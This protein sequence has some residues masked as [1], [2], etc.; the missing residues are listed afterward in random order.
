MNK[1]ARDIAR[2]LGAGEFDVPVRPSLERR[3][4]RAY[5]TMM[6]GDMLL[7]HF[8]FILAGLLYEGIWM[9]WRAQMQAQLLLPIFYT[10]ALYNGTY[11][12]RVLVDRRYAIRKALVALLISATLLNFV[13]FYTK[14]NASFSRGSFTIGMVL[15][16]ALLATFR[17]AVADMVERLWGGRIRNNLVIDDGGPPFRIAKADFISASDLGIEPVNDDP[18]TLDR[19]GRLLRNQD[20]VVVSCLPGRHEQWAFLLKA[21]GVQGEVVSEPVHTLGAIG[22]VQYEDQDL[23]ALVVSMG[24]LG[25]R[26][27]AA[28]RLFDLAVAIGG[29]I[30]LSPVLIAA[31][32]LIKLEDGG[33]VFFVQRRMGRGNRLFDMFKLR[34][35]RAE[36]H[37]SD[38]TLS[39]S[40]EDDRV[41]RIGKMLRATSLDE[42]PQLWNVIR[43]EMSIVGPR[44][45]ALGSRANEKL[46]WEVDRQYWKRHSLRPGLTG[47]AQVRGHRGSTEREE[48]LSDR[49]QCD[50]EYISGWSLQRDFAILW[51]TLS[52]LRHERAY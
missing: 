42:L 16:G 52:V 11:S 5:I 51:R 1:P 30:L 10:I 13:A 7:L 36:T 8:G 38:G 25:L 40:R 26:A 50:L 34:T 45:H 20:K 24:P 22:V 48:D 39:T 21:A 46:F 43:G 49:L 3:R 19:L 31:A 14:S 47:L 32:L 6:L 44:P 29:L 18:F 37:D 33:P 23:S 9:E 15:T 41:T 28:K 2:H 4:L 35:M 12:A 17:L 27:R